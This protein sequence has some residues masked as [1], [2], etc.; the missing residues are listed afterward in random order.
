MSKILALNFKMN[1]NYSDVKNYID[2]IK[3][4]I[5]NL[6]VIF[7]PPTIFLPYFIS[8]EYSIGSQTISEFDNGSHTGETSCTQLKSIGGKYV[9]IGNSERR[10]DQA[11]SDQLINLKIKQAL[12]NDLKVILCI[13]ETKEEREMLRTTRVLKKEITYDLKE[14]DENLYKNI[15]IAYEPLWSIGSGDILEKREI[16]ETI[17]YIKDTTLKIYNS[18]P[19]V[20]Y[21]G[22]VNEKSI[23]VLNEISNVG[24]FLVGGASLDY[25]KVLKMKEV[26]EK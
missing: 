1:F 2:N 15:I 7:F 5:N 26:V 14:L 25:K 12:A 11:E 16:E 9:I 24:G 13:G 19:I 8:N 23:E 3:G 18:D 4:K 22:S 21:G 20:L 6:D 10:R 17:N